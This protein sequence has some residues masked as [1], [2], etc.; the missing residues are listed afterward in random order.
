MLGCGLSLG[1]SLAL[2]GARALTWD[3]FP[4][5][6]LQH[7]RELLRRLKKDVHIH[8]DMQRQDKGK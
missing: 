1:L 6:T 3:S 8:K 4:E 7:L 2:W 5:L